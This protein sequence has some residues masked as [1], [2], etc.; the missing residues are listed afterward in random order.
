[1]NVQSAGI[2][3]VGKVRSSNEDHYGTFDEIGLY[4]VADGMGGHAAGEVASLMAVE[5]IRDTFQAAQAASDRTQPAGPGADPGRPIVWAIE[6][7]NQRIFTTGRNDPALSGMGTT[8]A[9]LW[10][11]GETAYVAHV[12][13]SRVYRLRGSVLEQITSDHSLINDY[14]SRG[15]MKP[16]EAAT[17]PMKHVLVRA[18]GTTASVA[19]DVKPVPLKPGDLFLLCSDGLSN[20]IP[21]AELAGT[22]ADPP[23]DLS[24][25]CQR[26]VDVANRHGGLDNITAVLVTA[27]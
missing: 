1:M 12:G 24:V 20:V 10:L 6:Q 25:R 11:S 13:D 9:A 15:I 27:T 18:L 2:T 19:V 7:A 16:D 26:L 8:I 17:H 22:L 3:H 5:T 4:V 23:A 21:H 14:L